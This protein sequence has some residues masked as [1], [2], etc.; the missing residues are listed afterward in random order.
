MFP[1]TF[2]NI[3]APE[4]YNVV[5]IQEYKYLLIYMLLAAWETGLVVCGEPSKSLKNSWKST[6]TDMA[7]PP[8][9]HPG[10]RDGEQTLILLDKPTTV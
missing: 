7:F 6:K 9:P 1:G 2:I 10:E 3:L 8:P 5:K 4:Y